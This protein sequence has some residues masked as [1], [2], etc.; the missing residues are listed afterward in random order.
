MYQK[1]LANYFL[2]ALDEQ[3]LAQ[4]CQV[5]NIHVIKFHKIHTKQNEWQNI[6]TLPGRVYVSSSVPV[7]IEYVKNTFTWTWAPPHPHSPNNYTTSA[8][9]FLGEEM[10]GGPLS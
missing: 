8:K 10:D 4:N 9:N 6:P 3:K 5:I 1:K 2:K 7:G